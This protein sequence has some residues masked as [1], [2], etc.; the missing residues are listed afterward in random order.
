MNIHDEIKKLAPNLKNCK[1]GDM[2]HVGQYGAGKDTT[3][4]RVLIEPGE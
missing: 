3:K 4:E 1:A 2:Y